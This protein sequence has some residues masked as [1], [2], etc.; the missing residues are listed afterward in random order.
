[1]NFSYFIQ[2]E[3]EKLGVGRSTLDYITQFLFVFEEVYL[4][5]Y[6]PKMWEVCAD[7]LNEKLRIYSILA[8]GMR[9]DDMQVSHFS[10]K[11][12]DYFWYEDFSIWSNYC[13]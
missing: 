8:K 5:H 7:L 6:F 4:A 3:G 11:S 1:M 12:I 9:K 13:L 2:G 10:V